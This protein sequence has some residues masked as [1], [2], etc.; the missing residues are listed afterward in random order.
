MSRMDMKQ[1][2]HMTTPTPSKRDR[3][4][5]LFYSYVLLTSN[6]RCSEDD[7]MFRDI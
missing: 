4:T 3:I 1:T 5:C 7:V 2:L 6:G